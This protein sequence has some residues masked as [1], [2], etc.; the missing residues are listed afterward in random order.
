M[1]FL[2]NTPVTSMLF[3]VVLDVIAGDPKSLWHPVMGVGKLIHLLERSLYR[4]KD[5]PSLR[6]R[7]GILLVLIGSTTVTLF[8]YAMLALAFKVSF[9][10]Y[11][12]LSV[13]FLWTGLAGR[14]LKQEGLN[15]HRALIENQLKE[16]RKRLSMLV[17]RQT[18]VMSEEEVIKAAVETVS[19]NT[20]DGILAPLFFGVLFGPCGMW[21]YKTVNT[22]DSMVGYK[23]QRYFDFG[24]CAAKTD[25]VL[26]FIPARLTA[27]FILFSAPIEGRSLKRAIEVYQKY[28][29]C[30]ESPNAGHPESAAAGVLGISLGGNAVYF[31]KPLYKPALGEAEKEPEP[32]DIVKTVRMMERAYMMSAVMFIMVTAMGRWVL[33]V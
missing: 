23:N 2:M 28:K 32:S 1:R 26:N 27:W 18:E 13:Y 19:E 24:W 33:H 29:N 15:V 25:D 22:M 17:S 16:A 5:T 10:L 20:S 8:V 4:E 6:K 3:A 30:H 11:Y 7:K 14:T 9:W 21:L 31:G 12:L